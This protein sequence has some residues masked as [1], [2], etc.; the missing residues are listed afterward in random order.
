MPQPYVHIHHRR[1]HHRHKNFR[2]KWISIFLISMSRSYANKMGRKEIVNLSFLEKWTQIYKYLHF[3]YTRVVV[4]VAMHTPSQWNTRSTKRNKEKTFLF[5]YALTQRLYQTCNNF[6][7]MRERERQCHCVCAR[8]FCVKMWKKLKMFFFF[9][10]RR[11]NIGF[12]LR[13]YDEHMSLCV[14]VSRTS[15]CVCV[16]FNSRCCLLS[17]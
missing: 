9:F 16:C 3:K 13:V 10:F 8:C 11:L 17:R 14:S 1:H 4:L 12:S 5:L 7:Y 6:C 15:V 2:I